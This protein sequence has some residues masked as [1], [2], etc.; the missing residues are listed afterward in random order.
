M[1]LD[2]LD[3]GDQEELSACVRDSS[4]AIEEA[5]L[6]SP[7][8]TEIFDVGSDDEEVEIDEITANRRESEEDREEETSGVNL[9]PLDGWRDGDCQPPVF[10]FTATPGICEDVSTLSTPL[11]F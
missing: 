10:P 2:N 9:Q 3:L 6:S 4:E 5:L 11:E 8:V 7:G 1:E